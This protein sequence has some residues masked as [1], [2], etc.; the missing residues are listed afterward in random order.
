MLLNRDKYKPQMGDGE[1][2]LEN[3]GEGSRG[4]QRRD[5]HFLLLTLKLS[6]HWSKRNNCGFVGVFFKEPQ[7][8]K[9]LVV[10][11]PQP[12]H[13]KILSM[14]SSKEKEIDVEL[15]LYR[16]VA[17]LVPGNNSYSM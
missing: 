4:K 16:R 2:S 8:R 12:K 11:I 5:R 9:S 15:R 17:K 7:H 1:R 14:F 10:R 13:V 6:M 3:L